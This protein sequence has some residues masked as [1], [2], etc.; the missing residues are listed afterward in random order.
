MYPIVSLKTEQPQTIPPKTWT[1]VRFPYDAESYDPL[2]MHAP[3]HPDGYRVKD[4]AKDS[5]SGLLWPDRADWVR[6]SAMIQWEPASSSGGYRELRDQIARDPL[7]LTKKG[8]DTTATDHR[9][10]TPGMQSFTK[11]WPIFAD[12]DVPLALRV[13][14]DDARARKV[15]L[16]ELK[17]ERRT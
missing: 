17:L 10:P 8:L 1:V 13:W 15:T 12:P 3:V 2:D 5:R 7:G 16:A 14:H 4:W 11:G 9:V 6:L